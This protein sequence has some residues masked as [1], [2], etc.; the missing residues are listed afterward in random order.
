[1]TELN[2]WRG[3]LYSPVHF[4]IKLNSSVWVHVWGKQRVIQVPFELRPTC[5][6]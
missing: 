6:G 4:A 1:M 2:K 5:M 3:G